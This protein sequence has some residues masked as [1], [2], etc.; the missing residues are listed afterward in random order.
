MYFAQHMNEQSHLQGS[1]DPKIADLGHPAKGRGFAGAEQHI[2][3]LEIPMHHVAGMEVV[4]CLRHLKQPAQ[5]SQL[6]QK[7][8][9]Q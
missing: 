8:H 4:H 9:I 7:E 5:Q 6:Q 2:C 3:R 1:A